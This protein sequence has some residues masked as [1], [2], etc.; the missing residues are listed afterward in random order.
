[1]AANKIYSGS[2]HSQLQ[3]GYP[4][5]LCDSIVN[6]AIVL[7]QNSAS[8]VSLSPKPFFPCDLGDAEVIRAI[9][10]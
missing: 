3:T 2:L 4:I 8:D 10:E 6:F 7:C 1:M 9:G 5:A